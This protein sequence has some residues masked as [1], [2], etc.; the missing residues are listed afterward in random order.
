MPPNLDYCPLARALNVV[1]DRWTVLI[2]RDLF[3]ARAARFQEFLDDLPGLG[4]NTLA[5]RLKKLESEGVV[6]RRFY[7]EHPPRAEYFLT[8]KGWELGPVLLALLA[9]GEKHMMDSESD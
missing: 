1:G 6:A 8:K 4:P 5:D 2:L 9:W 7:S 3:Q